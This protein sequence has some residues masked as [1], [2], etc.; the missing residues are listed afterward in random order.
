ML[1]KDSVQKRL[2]THPET[3]EVEI[4]GHTYKVCFTTWGAKA[5]RNEGINVV[6]D[7][8][9]FVR[10]FVEVYHELA[11]E[12]GDVFTEDTTVI[13]GAEVIVHHLDDEDLELTSKLLLWGLRTFYDQEEVT[14]DGIQMI[15]LK[16]QVELMPQIFPFLASFLQ[17]ETDSFDDI[18]EEAQTE[19]VP[20]GTEDGDGGNSR[21][22]TSN[23]D[24]SS[25]D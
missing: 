9:D 12:D 15:P 16:A 21:T 7:G 17:D 19:E 25:T 2:S 24:A 22:P 11:N 20:E 4:L 8:I 18:M 23:E 10:R 14:L 5:L 13:E 6:D 3:T 1:T